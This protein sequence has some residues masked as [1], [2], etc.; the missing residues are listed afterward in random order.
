VTAAIVQ[1]YLK[2]MARQ[3]WKLGYQKYPRD[4]QW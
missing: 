2:F 1:Q 4:S 3:T